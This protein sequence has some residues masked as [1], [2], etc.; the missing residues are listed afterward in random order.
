MFDYLFGD[1][2][3]AANLNLAAQLLMG[4]ALLFGARLARRGRF[5]A[6]GLCQS[7]VVLLNLIP[8]A[9]YM[10]PVFRRGVL[11]QL[12]AMLGDPFYALPAAHAALGSLAEALGLY[13]ILR[14]G[15]NVLPAALRFENY[16][17]WMRAELILWWVVIAL[18]LGTYG[19]WHRG[20]AAAPT[21]PAPDAVTAAPSDAADVSSAGPTPQIAAPEATVTMS[22]FAF[23]PRELTIE[24]GTTVVWKDS[25]GRHTVKADDGSF[26]S[27]V[28]SAGGE[29][30]RTFEREG[31]YPFHCTLHGAPGGQDMAGVIIV[32]PRARP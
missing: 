3:R 22:N 10:V 4:A 26:E 6:H 9:G 25:A 17:R 8:I 2:P 13:I 15:T 18:G 24:A 21:P 14:A 7:A 11:P 32:R 29:F 28:L 19:F 1:A 30:R 16:R 12:P 27:E 5:R 23:G 31:R 20:G